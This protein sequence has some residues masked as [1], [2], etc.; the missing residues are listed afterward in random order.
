MKNE[1]LETTKL[2]STLIVFE[3]DNKRKKDLKDPGIKQ[4]DIVA[5]KKIKYNSKFRKDNPIVKRTQS[6]EDI[7]SQFE[8]GASRPAPE[9]G[10]RR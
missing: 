7:V 2:A 6:E 4:N 9:H 3:R 10:R 8:K 5:I 1:K